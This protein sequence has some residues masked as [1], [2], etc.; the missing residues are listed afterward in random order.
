MISAHDLW[1]EHRVT[2]LLLGWL[3]L[4]PLASV[5][6]YVQDVA[7]F[8]R[9]HYGFVTMLNTAGYVRL[10]PMNPESYRADCVGMVTFLLLLFCYSFVVRVSK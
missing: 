8:I 6:V 10:D 4:Y 5:T 2:F 7:W 9:H 3:Y 1:Q